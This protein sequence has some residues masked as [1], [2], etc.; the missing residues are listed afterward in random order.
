MRP[1]QTDEE[2]HRQEQ[3]H[4]YIPDSGDNLVGYAAIKYAAIVII[5]IA[6][7]YFL[8]VYVMPP[9]GRR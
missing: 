8:A 5:V 7:L 9:L 6:V 2:I 3:E 1:K 4:D